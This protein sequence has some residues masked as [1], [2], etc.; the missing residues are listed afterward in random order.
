MLVPLDALLPDGSRLPYG[1]KT[2]HKELSSYGHESDGNDN[3]AEANPRVGLGILLLEIAFL[4]LEG[5]G[6]SWVECECIVFAG[7]VV[8]EDSRADV[9]DVTVSVE[10]GPMIILIRT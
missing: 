1:F 5:I 3:G 8:E 2:L 4:F 10:R 6:G 9:A 7:R